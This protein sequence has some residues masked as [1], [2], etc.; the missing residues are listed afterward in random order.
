MGTSAKEAAI[1]A[2]FQAVL[3][4]GKRILQE[5]YQSGQIPQCG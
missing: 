3:F 1:T 4:K 5:P 2:S